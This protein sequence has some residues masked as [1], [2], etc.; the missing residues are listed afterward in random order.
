MEFELSSL[1][2]SDSVLGECWPRFMM[3]VNDNSVGGWFGLVWFWFS[4]GYRSGG[5]G[6]V[7]SCLAFVIADYCSSSL[8]PFFSRYLYRFTIG[9]RACN[10]S[11]FLDFGASACM[12]LGKCSKCLCVVAN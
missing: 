4:C 1:E 8:L 5:V 6:G 10:R 2:G 11:P 7:L 12:R 3:I 9:M